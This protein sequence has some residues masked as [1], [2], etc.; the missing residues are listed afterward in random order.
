MGSL[1]SGLR[2]VLPL[3]TPPAF[4]RAEQGAPVF[5]KL[6][7]VIVNDGVWDQS[8]G[9]VCFFAGK[10]KKAAALRRAD[11]S[12]ADVPARRRP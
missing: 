4:R 10:F 6:R 1:S 12:R 11:A 9:R 5:D 7:R 3:R 2:P 8:R